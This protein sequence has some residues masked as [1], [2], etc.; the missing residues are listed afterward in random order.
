MAHGGGRYLLSGKVHGKQFYLTILDNGA[1]CKNAVIS[2]PASARLQAET[3]V[4]LP[5]AA[6][7]KG[8]QAEQI[9]QILW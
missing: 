9:W 2:I 6:F 1:D 5:P 7:R 4:C 3:S 8:E